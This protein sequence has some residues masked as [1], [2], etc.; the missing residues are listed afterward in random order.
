[1]STGKLNPTV[2]NI[3][4]KPWAR[5]FSMTDCLVNR[6]R[7]QRNSTAAGLLAVWNGDSEDTSQV[8]RVPVAQPLFGGGV[9][10]AAATPITP[11]MLFGGG[12]L[13]ATAL[14][15]P[16]HWALVRHPPAPD[17][18]GGFAAS[19]SFFPATRQAAVLHA[20]RPLREQGLSVTVVDISVTKPPSDAYTSMLNRLH[21]EAR[22]GERRRNAARARRGTAKPL[23]T[24]DPPEELLD[25]LDRRDHPP[26]GAPGGQLIVCGGRPFIPRKPFEFFDPTQITKNVIR[27]DRHTFC[28]IPETNG[29]QAAITR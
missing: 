16:P 10:N 18:Y 13:S 23:P 25:P 12:A 14:A 8:R 22:I 2:V 28:R 6:E 15:A 21:T 4:K 3:A 27:A 9:L 29:H 5:P 1:M 24:P 11:I 17:R 7:R 20:A 26:E 19:F